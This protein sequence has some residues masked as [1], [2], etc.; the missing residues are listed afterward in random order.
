MKPAA[1]KKRFNCLV[2][3]LHGE[4]WISIVAAEKA[5]KQYK[6]LIKNAD[7]L[8][9]AKKF[10]INDDRVDN[11]YSKIFDSSNT[12]D[13]ENVVRLILILSLGNASVEAGF[14]IN[15]DNLSS[16]MLEESI[17]TQRIVYEA[18]SKAGDPTNVIIDRELLKIVKDSHR[19][20][21][22]AQELKKQR[23]SEA[24][25]R[26]QEKS[27]ATVDFKNTVAKKKAVIEEFR[28]R[29]SE[30]DSEIH[31]LQEKLRK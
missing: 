8:S 10:N 27:K 7:F 26:V 6:S 25:Q 19:Q 2:L 16:N 9:E 28:S 30:F 17:I 31:A 21:A 20:Y 1:L 5:E 12:I 13:L 29:I 4:H 11:F 3:S 22:A 15:A 18:V 23:Q 24:Q 14:S